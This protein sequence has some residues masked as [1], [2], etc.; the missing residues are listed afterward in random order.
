[1]AVYVDP[2]I[3]YGWKLGPSCHMTADTL[4]E[5]H[6]MAALI[7]MKAS[8]FQNKPG[9]LPHYDLVKSRRTKA[10]QLGAIKITIRQMGERVI[11]HRKQIPGDIAT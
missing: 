6:I 4:E 11:Q 8:W 5:L 7:G 2:L 3:N 10:I 9:S 1:M